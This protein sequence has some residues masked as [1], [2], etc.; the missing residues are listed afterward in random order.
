MSRSLG[1]LEGR[2][3]TRI[4]PGVCFQVHMRLDERSGPML[5]VVVQHKRGEVS[6]AV[7]SQKVRT[8]CSAARTVGSPP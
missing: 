7:S 5:Q 2:A 6:G 3:L 1:V 4:Q 8:T